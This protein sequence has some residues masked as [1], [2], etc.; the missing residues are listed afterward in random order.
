MSRVVT[1]NEIKQKHQQSKQTNQI[2]QINQINQTKQSNQIITMTDNDDNDTETFYGNIFNQMKT[3]IETQ[4]KEIEDKTHR[5]NVVEKAIQLR[6]DEMKQRLAQAND[7]IKKKE[8][9]LRML[10]QEASHYRTKE[11]TRNEKR[12][13]VRKLV[14][15]IYELNIKKRERTINQAELDADAR[16]YLKKFE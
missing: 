11:S 13:D 14:N 6:N 2:N 5:L 7:E 12:M 15:D 9:E 3:V 10:E 8:L 1:L 4:N 16:E